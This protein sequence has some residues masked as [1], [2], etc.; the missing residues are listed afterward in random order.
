MDE[1][2]PIIA[3]AARFQRKGGREVTARSPTR[4]DAQAAAS[5]LLDRMSR[6]HPNLAV[7]SRGEKTAGQYLAS[8]H[9]LS[10]PL[11]YDVP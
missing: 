8:L 3:T 9:V 4:E 10:H 6:L 11:D 5:W 2:E 1:P 7:S